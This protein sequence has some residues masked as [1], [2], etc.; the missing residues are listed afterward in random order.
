MRNPLKLIGPFISKH[1]PEIL[2][3]MGIGGLIFSTFWGIKATFKAA[4]TIDSYK[5]EKQIDKVTPKEAFKLTWKYYWPVVASAAVSIP[6][7]IAGNRVSN[8]RYTALAAAYTISETA[9]QE[10]QE[11]TRAVVGEKKAKQIQETVDANKI[12]QTYR[13]A[14]QIIITG[15]GDSLFFEPLSGRYF[16]SNWNAISKAANEL[17]ADALSGVGG[18][19]S[20]NE[21]FERLGLDDTEIGDSIGWRL[22]NDPRNLIDIEI[23]S[24]ITKDDKPCGAISYR[25]QP[26][27][28]NSSLY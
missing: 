24:H 18:Q 28:L 4:R 26:K 7:I 23:S 9:L 6:C 3:G 17:N 11:A 22:D 19:I 21:W 15:N 16:V 10:Y 14:N 2:M 27:E 13:G 12:E 25:N 5:E 1:E 8:K 20:L